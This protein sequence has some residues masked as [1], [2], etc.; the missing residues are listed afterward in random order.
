MREKTVYIAPDKKEFTSKE[1]CERYEFDLIDRNSS[2]KVF[3]LSCQAGSDG[4]YNKHI[5]LKFEYT[6]DTVSPRNLVLDYCMDFIGSPVKVF[7]GTVINNWEISESDII[8]Y[9]DAMENSTCEC[10]PLR[11]H[12]NRGLVYDYST[13]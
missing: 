11:L 5:L 9:V 6:I 8:E 12:T 2:S 13:F 1:E 3:K 7:K 10:R 4:K